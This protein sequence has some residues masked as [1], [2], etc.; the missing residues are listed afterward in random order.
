MSSDTQTVLVIGIGMGLLIWGPLAAIL[1][2]FKR[3]PAW[4]G[5]LWGVFF[6]LLAFPI[7][8]FFPPKAKVSAQSMTPTPQQPQVVLPVSATSPTWDV[9]PLPVVPPARA[10]S[11]APALAP[12]PR[13][14][15]LH[16]AP[17]RP[18]ANPVYPQ[19]RVGNGPLTGKAVSI[20][21]SRFVIGR[22]RRCHLCLD[23]PKISRQHIQITLEGGQYYLWDLGAQNGTKVNHGPVIQKRRLSDG[24]EIWLGRVAL[25]KFSR[26]PA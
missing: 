14:L 26:R 24:D 9:P 17:Q 13:G 18:S 11:V 20:D 23:H 3:Y 2:H 21:R 16:R 7:I 25:L 4:Q 10:V 22:S 8:L 12:A 1:A 5:Y 6:G 19:L 15:T